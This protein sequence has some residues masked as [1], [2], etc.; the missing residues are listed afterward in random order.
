MRLF[1]IQFGNDPLV[2]FA[3]VGPGLFGRFEPHARIL[4]HKR[5]K[6]AGD[7]VERGCFRIILALEFDPLIERVGIVV[8]DREPNIVGQRQQVLA[9]R[10]QVFENLCVLADAE[11]FTGVIGRNLVRSGR[12]W[13]IVPTAYSIV[14]IFLEKLA[15]ISAPSQ[16][17]AGGRVAM[18]GYLAVLG[19]CSEYASR[20]SACL[21][22][23][24]NFRVIARFGH[25]GA[26]VLGPLDKTASA[27]QTLQRPDSRALTN[28]SGCADCLTRDG[29]FG[30]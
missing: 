5:R 25:C 30:Q 27:Y 18:L 2:P 17:A 21:R 3:I 1:A 10:F 28:D 14:L 19:P 13:L 4:L 8:V 22:G 12:K 20:D 29:K 24:G 7:P 15:K 16:A 23:L 6:L 9:D 26:P 11:G